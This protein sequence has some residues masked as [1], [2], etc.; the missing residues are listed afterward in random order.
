MRRKLDLRWIAVGLI[1]VPQLALSQEGASGLEVVEVDEQLTLVLG[2]GGNSAIFVGEDQ[3][4][5]IDTKGGESAKA[6]QALVA[7]KAAGRALTIIN[8]HYHGDHIRG[9]VLYP[10]ARVM[11]GAYAR[12]EWEEDA[13]G[14]PYPDVVI[15]EETEIELGSERLRLLPMGQAHT[16]SDVVVIFQERGVMLT[17][18]LIFEGSHPV[19]KKEHGTDSDKWER[20]LERLM[21]ACACGTVVPGHGPVSDMNALSRMRDYFAEIR[22]ALGDEERLAAVRAK[23]GGRTA[24]PNLSGFDVTV[25]YM[26]WEAAGD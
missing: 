11:A 17:G 4:V 10:G 3:A 2:R 25:D 24:Y 16:W 19:M 26:R 8:T 15:E 23:Y 13:G 6:L 22:G 12:E 7:E 9:N 18:D 20:A 14:V 5:V 21:E 1:L